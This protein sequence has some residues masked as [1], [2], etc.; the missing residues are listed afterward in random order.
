MSEI[1]QVWLDVL[2]I[3]IP[4]L[5]IVGGGAAAY[6]KFLQEQENKKELGKKDREQALADFQLGFEKLSADN[7]LKID[8]ATWG[9]LQETLAMQ[10]KRI[11]HLEEEVEK[12]RAENKLLR[13]MLRGAL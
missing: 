13:D 5:L 2:Q 3:I 9:R 4:A 8:E 7:K 1:S 10:T 11:D 6:W 12:L